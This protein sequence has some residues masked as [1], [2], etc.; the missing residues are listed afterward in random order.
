[1]R[2]AY[3]EDLGPSET[4]RSGELPD[5]EPGPSDVLVDVEYTAVNH[6]D[7]FVRSGAWRTPVPFPF[8]VGRDLVGTVVRAGPG[9]PSFTP[10]TRVWSLS[11]G[12]AG[13]QGAC[14]ERAAVPAD[15]LYPLPEGADPVEAVALAH[16]AAT[17]YLA[18][19]VHGRLR[20][21]ET[22]VV[23]GAGGN[24]GS[25]LVAMAAHAGARVVAVAGA[26]DA[27]YCRGQG[28]HEVVDYRAPDAAERIAAACPGGADLYIDAAGRNDVERALPLLAHRGRMVVLA[29]MGTRPTLPAGS[30]YL[31]D[32]T[33][34][35]FAISQATTPELAEAA[36]HVGRLAR[37]GVLRPRRCRVLPLDQAARAHRDL[38][39]G[40]AHG[41]RYVL[42]VR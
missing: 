4:I 1:M 20:A 32:R 27:D 10:G 39:E 18:L 21:G 9:A 15:R 14:A 37:A 40:R 23:V 25:A 24:V 5:P 31:L 35:G 22:L 19:F 7:T 13:R 2:S 33:V 30:L 41:V 12:Y 29:G 26:Q 42:R 8:V 36:R 6:V 17:A 28:A 16:P 11:M 38:E 3:I 34:T